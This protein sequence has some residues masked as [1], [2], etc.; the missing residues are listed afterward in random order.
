LSRV[1]TILFIIKQTAAR[2]ERLANSLMTEARRLDFR[3]RRERSSR[4]ERR[5]TG[6]PEN[7]DDRPVIVAGL[8]WA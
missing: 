8:A 5:L 6:R 4:G 3:H 7:D 2:V 1:A